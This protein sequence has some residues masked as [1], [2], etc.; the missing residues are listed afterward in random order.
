[1]RSG[2]MDSTRF[3]YLQKSITSAAP[4]VCPASAVPP[5][6]GRTG[7][8]C[9]A[10]SRRRASHV[11]RVL[12]G[13]PRRRGG[14]GRATRRCCRAGATWRRSAL[15]RGCAPSARSRRAPFA[16]GWMTS[17]GLWLPFRCGAGA[18]GRA[19]SGR[20]RKISWRRI[21]GTRR[22]TGS[23]ALPE[24]PR[25]LPWQLR[26]Q[27]ASPT[28]R[29]PPPANCAGRGGERQGALSGPGRERL[30]PPQRRRKAPQTARGFNCQRQRQ[31]SPTL[32]LSF[33]RR[34]TPSSPRAHDSGARLRN[35]LGRNHEICSTPPRPQPPSAPEREG[36]LGGRTSGLQQQKADSSV[37]ARVQ[38][39]G[40]GSARRLSR[41]DSRGGEDGGEADLVVAAVSSFALSS[42]SGRPT[43]NR[44]PT[45]VSSLA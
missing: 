40:G 22:A 37:G 38:C 8:P 18:R 9:S 23:A 3:M 45:M 19:G 7:T 33:R 26:R 27:T 30:K 14:S 17:M 43:S 10:A 28:P 24:S 44:P 16:S 21:S 20:F 35:L 32:S 15:R 5:P 36:R 2:S 4:T 12:A 25:P 29:P 31:R 41:N 34:R 11:L 1:M 42:A 39:V 6:R 13:G